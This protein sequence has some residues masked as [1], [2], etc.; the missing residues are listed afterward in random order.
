MGNFCS[1]MKL[2]ISLLLLATLV[3]ISV[4]QCTIA[5]LGRTIIELLRGERHEPDPKYDSNTIQPH[6]NNTVCNCLQQSPIFGFYLSLSVSIQYVYLNEDPSLLL[7]IRFGLWCSSGVWQ[8][9]GIVHNEFMNGTRSDCSDCKDMTVND[10]H[11]T[12]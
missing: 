2:L 10:H 11:C 6:I 1:M 9:V 12:R 4:Q 8:R 7:A 5:S 3:R